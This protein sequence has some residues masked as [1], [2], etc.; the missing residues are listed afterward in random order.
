MEPYPYFNSSIY[1]NTPYYYPF[2]QNKRFPL[3]FNMNQTLKTAQKTLVTINQIIPLIYQV[4]PLIH[5]AKTAF[6]V[7]KAVNQMDLN[8]EQNLDQEINR[9]LSPHLPLQS[10]HNFENML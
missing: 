6:Q 1:F 10:V 3:T 8:Q 5:N 2:P 9:E 7:I 4:Q